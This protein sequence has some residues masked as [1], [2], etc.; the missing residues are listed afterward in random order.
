M[1]VERRDCSIGKYIFP[2]VHMTSVAS[3]INGLINRENAL[4]VFNTQHTHTKTHRLCPGF[5]T[6]NPLTDRQRRTIQGA[7]GGVIP[8]L[9]CSHNNPVRLARLRCLVQG[10]P[11]SFVAPEEVQLLNYDHPGKPIM[12]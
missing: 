6:E 4:K 12:Q 2:N 7:K 3:S 11:E 10:H 8:L 9:P 1:T 5:L